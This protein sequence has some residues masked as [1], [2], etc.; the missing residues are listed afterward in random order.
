MNKIILLGSDAPPSGRC[1]LLGKAIADVAAL[2]GRE[3]LRIAEDV[4]SSKHGSNNPVQVPLKEGANTDTLKKLC[5]E[6]QIT[7]IDPNL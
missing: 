7:I 4:F 1:L 2:P 6:Y 3:C 5:S